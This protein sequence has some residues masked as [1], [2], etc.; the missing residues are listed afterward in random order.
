MGIAV[1]IAIVL[2]AMAIVPSAGPFMPAIF[3]SACAALVGAIAIAFGHVRRGILTIYLALSAAVVS[4]VLL[5]VQRVDIWLVILPAVGALFGSL[6]FLDY[7]R[8][9]TAVDGEE[10]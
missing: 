3:L 5:E 9:K 7:N 6:L 10:I 1:N 2:A 4:P 8:R